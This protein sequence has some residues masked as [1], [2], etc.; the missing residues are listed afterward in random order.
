MDDRLWIYRGSAVSDLKVQQ[1]IT[2]SDSF[3]I[4][5]QG[6]N[7]SPFAFFEA[8]P[9]I[10]PIGTQVPRPVT[11]DDELFEAPKSGTGIHHGTG[12][13]DTDRGT[14]R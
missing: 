2:R 3:N 14:R 13:S 9:A 10:E 7:L 1:R 12:C 11:Q 5:N 6:P 4:G 8:A